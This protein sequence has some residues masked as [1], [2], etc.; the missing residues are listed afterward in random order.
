MAFK[1]VTAVSIHSLYLSIS[2]SNGANLVTS[3]FFVLSALKTS[4]DLS[5]GSILILS[6]LTNC[7]LIL[8]WVYPE[9]TNACSCNSFPFF[10]LMLVCMFNSLSL[11]FIW[12][13]ITYQF[14]DLL[15]TKIC[16]IMP[17]LNLQQNPPLSHLLN[18]LL[19]SSY[20]SLA[21]WIYNP[22]LGVLLYHICNTSLFLQ[23]S[24]AF[25]IHWPC[26]HISC[27]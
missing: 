2:T 16:H 19:D 7:S 12:F 4:K 20:S 8:V 13:G 25:C 10:V 24:W 27:N 22:W 14:W 1:S 11:L 23:L 5:I 17:T 15:C 18:H 26:V 9:S 21:I 3:P 6:F